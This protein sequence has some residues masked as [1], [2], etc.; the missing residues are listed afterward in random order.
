MKMCLTSFYWNCGVKRRRKLRELK[1]LKQNRNSNKIIMSGYI[2]EYTRVA[3]SDLIYNRRETI[4]RY[5]DNDFVR[6]CVWKETLPRSILIQDVKVIY[7]NILKDI[8]AGSFKHLVD[9]L[10]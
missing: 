7:Q 10:L 3:R 1:S 5:S 6:E 8:I 2:A 9:Y 4:M